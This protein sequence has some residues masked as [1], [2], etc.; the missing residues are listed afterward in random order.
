ATVSLFGDR[1]HACAYLQYRP[2]PHEMV[3]TIMNYVKERMPFPL[4]LAVDVGC[5]SGQG[6]VLLAPHFTRV[7]GTDISPAQLENA[8]LNQQPPNVT[9]SLAPSDA[10]PLDDE[11]VDLVT[12]MSAAHW[13]HPE[14]FLEEVHRVLRPGGCVALFSYPI[15]MDVEYGDSSLTHLCQEFYSAVSAFRHPRI[16]TKSVD[17]YKKMFL[18]CPYQD[19]EW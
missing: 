6:T 5:G 1:Q 15:E 2:V 14:H 11:S 10:L 8:R 19:K 9:Y 16:G 18:S 17:I 3:H 7:V 4:E 13:F 12:A